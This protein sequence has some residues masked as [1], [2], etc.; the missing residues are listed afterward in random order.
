MYSTSI[1]VVV[2]VEFMFYNCL[3]YSSGAFLLRDLGGYT[4]YPVPCN[5]Y[6]LGHP[7][8]FID[9]TLGNEKYQNNILAD[10]ES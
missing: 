5:V 9:S 7:V 6:G 10:K 2:V 1:V 4:T 3:K 8:I